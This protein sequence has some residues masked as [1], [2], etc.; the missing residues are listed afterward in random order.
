MRAEGG[1]GRWGFENA[2]VVEEVGE[3]SDEPEGEEVG[4]LEGLCLWRERG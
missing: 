3:V 4:L 1:E 2:E